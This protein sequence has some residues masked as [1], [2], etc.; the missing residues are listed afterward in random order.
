[1]ENITQSI[2]NKDSIWNKIKVYIYLL[3][4]LISLLIVLLI[5]IL[6]LNIIIYRKLINLI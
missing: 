1:M 3:V 6:I 2:I 5:S 4:F